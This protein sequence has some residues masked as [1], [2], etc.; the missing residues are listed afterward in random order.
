[1]SGQFT[2]NSHMAGNCPSMPY[3]REDR[4]NIALKLL[5]SLM[6]KH[7]GGRWDIVTADF[8]NKPI[9]SFASPITI[10]TPLDCHPPACHNMPTRLVVAY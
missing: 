5:L 10:N 4:H 1:M 2:S 3:L 9:K 6:G 7:N 8:G